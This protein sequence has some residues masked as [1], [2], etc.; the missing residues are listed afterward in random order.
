MPKLS[1]L[2]HFIKGSSA[3]LGFLKIQASCER[4]QRYGLHEDV[5]G[6]PGLDT[7]TC[8]DNI[9][10]TLTAVDSELAE[11]K[12]QLLTFYGVDEFGEPVDEEKKEE[13][14]HEHDHDHDE[15]NAA[16]D[17]EN[18]HEVNEAD[19]ANE[20]LHPKLGEHKGQPGV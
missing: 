4:I 7:A 19:E 1:N 11:V 3:A 9:R 17:L 10:H 16:N 15:N 2:G 12:D 13:H 5:D 14:E 18:G 8:L 20:D 6:T